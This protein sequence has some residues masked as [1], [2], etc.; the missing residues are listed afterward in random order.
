MTQIGTG[1]YTY[2]LTRDFCKLPAG[3]SFGLVSRVAADAQDRIYV[4]QRKD[5]PVVVFD[6][7]GKYLGDMHFAFMRNIGDVV[8]TLGTAQTI[9]TIEKGIVSIGL[10]RMIRGSG[11][12]I[13]AAERV[14]RPSGA[15]RTIGPHVIRGWTPTRP[16]RGCSSRRMG[17]GRRRRSG[18]GRRRTQRSRG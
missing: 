11:R 18:S 8:P 14:I 15:G 17:G 2:E 5:P 12:A 9:P 7:E 10:T 3:Q 1:K 4:F 16:C 13:A 6:R